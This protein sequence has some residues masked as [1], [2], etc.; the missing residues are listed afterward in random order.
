MKDKKILIVEDQIEM[1]AINTLFLER[2]GYRVMAVDNGAE[3]IRSAREDQPDLIIMDLS[4]PI[5]NGFEATEQIKQN[6]ETGHIPVVVLTAFSYGSAGR[7]AREAGCDAF[8]TKPC[9]PQRLLM[10]VQQRIGPAE[11]QIH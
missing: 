8:I 11:E 5:V 9:N 7:R 1:R 3:G 4:I 6:P 2:H 10:E